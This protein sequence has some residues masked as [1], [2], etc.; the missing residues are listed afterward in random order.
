MILL[1]LQLYEEVLK[2]DVIMDVTNEADKEEVNVY[3][4][5]TRRGLNSG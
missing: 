3:S 2:R 5:K 4:C 1:K